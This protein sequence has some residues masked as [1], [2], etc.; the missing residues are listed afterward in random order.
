MPEDV[1]EFFEK[2]GVGL[3]WVADIDD[4]FSVYAARDINNANRFMTDINAILDDKFD[5]EKNGE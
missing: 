2:A 3:L 4:D 5:K 1:E